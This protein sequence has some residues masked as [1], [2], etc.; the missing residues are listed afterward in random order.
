M[1]RVLQ[2]SW[3]DTRYLRTLVYPLLPRLAVTDGAGAHASLAA[4]EYL[5]C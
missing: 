2:E 1:D 3:P 5:A 4:L